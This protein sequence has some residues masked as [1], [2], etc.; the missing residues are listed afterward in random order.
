MADN[1]RGAAYSQLY[2]H[3]VLPRKVPGKA[4]HNIHQLESDLLDRL[5]VAVK[6]LS[7]NVPPQHFTSVDAVRVALSKCKDLHIDGNIDKRRLVEELRQLEEGQ[8]LLLYVTEQNVALLL[9][10]QPEWV[11]L[12]L[13]MWSWLTQ[14]KRYRRASGSFRSV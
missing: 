2:H 3:V 5:L 4:D 7:A 8:S 13:H 1:G 10:K 9:F 6:T 14:S 12:H 11:Y